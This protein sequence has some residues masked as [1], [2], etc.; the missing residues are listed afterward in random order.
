MGV[1]CSAVPFAF[2]VRFFLVVSRLTAVFALRKATAAAVGVF[3]SAG[4]VSWK[5]GG[6]AA[7][8]TNKISRPF[9]LVGNE[10]SKHKTVGQR[11]PR[12][13]QSADDR[14]TPRQPIDRNALL[15]TAA[16]QLVSR[17]RINGEPASRGKHSTYE[18]L[19]RSIRQRPQ[20]FFG[21]LRCDLRSYKF[22]NCQKP[23]PSSENS[24]WL[25]GIFA[26]NIQRRR[27]IL[28]AARARSDHKEITDRR[29]DDFSSKPFSSFII[30][31]PLYNNGF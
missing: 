1:W 5:P 24:F 19:P 15:A 10:T 29:C 9:F 20:A 12:K 13:L 11:Q 6:I 14:T 30:F 25:P 21:T 2:F 7:N 28:P 17:I 3:K 4:A 26:G 27:V 18:I 8:S 23:I 31:L 22:S 16:N